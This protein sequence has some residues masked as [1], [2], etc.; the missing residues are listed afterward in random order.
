[1]SLEG[2]Y[3]VVTRAADQQHDLVA[4]LEARGAIA[5]PYPCITIVPPTDLGPMDNALRRMAANGFDWLVLTSTNTVSA[6][7]QRCGILGLTPGDLGQPRIAAVG[8]ATADAASAWL[9]RGVDV[10]SEKGHGEDLASTLDLAPGDRV[11]LPQS[12]IAKPAL[13]EALGRME[14]EITVVEAYTTGLG[15]G[16]EDVPALLAAGQ[17]DA[18]TFTS[19][20]TVENFLARLRK[21]GGMDSLSP[22]ICI[23]CIGRPTARTA[24]ECGMVVHVVPERSDLKAMV[25]RMDAMGEAGDSGRI[26]PG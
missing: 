7:A 21:E 3:V 5:V 6:L 12:A 13:A 23:A 8:G 11:F 17:I 19:G 15:T 26:A 24:R 2:K 1:M 25:E 16:G 9:Q 18:I 4:L 10:V 20:S 22:R 14:A